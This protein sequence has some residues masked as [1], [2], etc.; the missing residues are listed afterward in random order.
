V[1]VA[2]LGTGTMGAA[3]ARNIAGADMDVRVWNRSRERAEDTGLEVADSPAAA[4]DGADVMLTMLSDGDV[5]DDVAREALGGLRDDAVWLQMST[6]G[7][8]ANERLA[9]IASEHGVP[10][11]DA[12]VVGT[13]QP[14]EQGKLTVLASGPKDARERAKPVFD[15]VAASVVELGDA[16]EGSAL[17]IVVNSWLAALVAGLAE[18]IALAE[19]IGVDP[20]VFLETI[21]G[22]PTGPQ[23]A[24]L[25]GGAMIAGEYPTAFSLSLTRKDV[26]LVIE[27]AES[28]GFDAKLARSIAALFD[29]AIEDG[30]GAKDMAAVIEAYR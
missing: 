21:E 26:G 14:A 20:K 9:A 6:V 30:H 3:M 25:K 23:Y 16:G 8:A 1:L 2:V 19:A 15:A 7:I 10:F 17:K 12:P 5:V 18:T 13:R 29:R 27:A 4:V 28:K 11:V 24:Q 22:G